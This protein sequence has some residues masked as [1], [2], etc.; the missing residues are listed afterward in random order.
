[1]DVFPDRA[2]ARIFANQTHDYN[3]GIT[4]DG[5]FWTLLIAGES[6]T[7]SERRA[8]LCIRDQFIPDMHTFENAVVRG[9]MDPATIAIDCA[10]E[11]TS[12]KVERDRNEEQQ[13]VFSF[14]EAMGRVH[15]RATGPSG[16]LRSIMTGEP[17]ETL[18][19][20]FGSE[21]NGVFFS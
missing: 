11:A 18:Y 2:S 7:R 19:G 15:W 4:D 3:P 13:Y 6:A 20:A 21:R 16:N 8:D 9:P 14:R 10:W 1:M 12:G 5:L 17:Q